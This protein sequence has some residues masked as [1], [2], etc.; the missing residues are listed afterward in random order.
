MNRN[1]I[2]VRAESRFLRLG[3]LVAAAAMSSLFACSD[4][5][6][7]V[8]DIRTSRLSVRDTTHKQTTEFAQ[9]GSTAA[10]VDE[11]TLVDTF[12]LTLHPLLLERCSGCHSAAVA[13]Y[14]ASDNVVQAYKAITQGGKVD[15]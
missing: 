9:E 2:A 6:T 12:Q 3:L 5:G 1:R 13:P 4:E 15:F 7:E 10:N 8:K 14:F 11:A